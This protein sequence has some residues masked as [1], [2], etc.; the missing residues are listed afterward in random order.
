MANT[1]DLTTAINWISTW[2]RSPDTGVKAF[3]I[4][5]IDFSSLMQDK[6]CIGV[7]AYLAFGNTDGNPAEAKLLLVDVEGDINT[8]GTD[9]LNNGIYDF[10]R[11]CPSYCDV[12]SPLYTLDGSGQYPIVPGNTIDIRTAVDWA[13]QWRLTPD[14]N[15]KAF[16]IPKDDITDLLKDSSCI[17]VR[18]YLGW[19]GSDSK[20]PEAKL[21]MV[22]VDGNINTGGTDNITNGIFDFTRPCPSYCDV[23]S[24][25]YTLIP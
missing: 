9:N 13:T 17:G 25:L 19:G 22:N 1:I 21:M 24:S 7:R 4:P 18:A 14:T 11:P 10:T 5:V 12:T 2:R 16:F 8:G 20:N 23:T 6:N 15:V 3:F